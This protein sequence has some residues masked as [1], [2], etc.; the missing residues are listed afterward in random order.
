MRDGP[1]ISEGATL[2]HLMAD[3]TRLAD[4]LNMPGVERAGIL[5]V[6]LDAWPHWSP[7]SVLPERQA[8][9]RRR[10]EYALP[11]MR[12]TLGEAS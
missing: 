9:Y 1:P 4:A 12:R 11:L 7:D 10:L 6:S 2:A 5:G 8:E 3:F